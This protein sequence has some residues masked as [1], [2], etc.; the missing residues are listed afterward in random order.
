MKSICCRAARSLR[1]VPP[2]F[3][4]GRKSGHGHSKVQCRGFT[5]VSARRSAGVS[6]ESNRYTIGEQ[7]HDATMCNGAGLEGVD[8]TKMKSSMKLVRIGAQ[9]F[10]PV[11]LRDACPCAQCIDPS[12]KQK[13]FQTTDIPA[14]MTPASIETLDNGDTQITW[15][16]D[17]PGFGPKHASNYPKRFFKIHADQRRIITDRFDDGEPWTWGKDEISKELQ[18]IDYNDYMTSDE[19]LYRAITQLHCIGL[20]LL[21]RVPETETAVEDVALRIGNLRDSLYGRTWDVKAVPESRNVAYRAQYLGLHMDLLY[22][23]NPPGYQFL[24]CLKNSCEGG[25]SIFSD[26]FL[27]AE[28]LNKSNFEQLVRYEVAYHYRNAGEHYYF[29]HPVIEA[30]HDNYSDGWKTLNVNYSPPFQ[31]NHYFPSGR[32]QQAQFESLLEATRE[33]ASLVESPE[34]L[35]EYRLQEGECIIFNNRRVLHGRRQFDSSEG[36]RWLKGAYIDTDVF[37]SRYRVL[38]EEFQNM[39]LAEMNAGA[40]FVNA[41]GP[42]A[43]AAEPLENRLEEI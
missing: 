23:A 4:Y 11:F 18:F 10:H 34:H 6:S 21:R 3:K 24:H 31:A 25:S 19:A 13:N 29:L 41:R 7:E 33:F 8:T 17:L 14:D 38:S 2:T 27:A 1:S 16:R 40:T 28:K 26:S 35:F 15:A 12:S 37:K 39:S 36:E 30:Q 20:L 5:D 9:D 22:M 32:E 43:P 42:N